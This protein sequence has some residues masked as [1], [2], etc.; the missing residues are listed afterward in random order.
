MGERHGG[1]PGI[2]IGSLIVAKFFCC[3]ALVI[4]V[5]G[6]FGVA[7]AWFMDSGLG[8]FFVFAFLALV[9]KPFWWPKPDDSRSRDDNRRMNVRTR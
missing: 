4:A 5:S 7:G 9:T 8:W 1:E 3:G 6:G 2:G